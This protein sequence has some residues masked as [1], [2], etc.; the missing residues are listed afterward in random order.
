MEIRLGGNKGLS[1]FVDD[2]DYRTFDLG[3]YKWCPINTGKGLYYARAKKNGKEIRLHRLIMGLLDSPSSVIVDHIDH[4]G[5]NNYRNNLRTTDHSNNMRNSRKH[6]SAKSTSTY[7]G[8]YFS[9][10]NKNP[11]LA[12][13]KLSGK[14][15]H[16]GYYRT[17]IEAAQS[18]NKAAFELFGL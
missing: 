15:K 16:L 8:V 11:W 13:I 5:L 2:E 14:D 1:T 9:R 12:R 10:N 3:S 18:Y 7:K 6:L 17:E 4:N